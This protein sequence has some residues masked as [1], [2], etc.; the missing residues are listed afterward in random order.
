MSR[1][2]KELGGCWLEA[3]PFDMPPLCGDS[4]S[5]VTCNGRRRDQ[6]GQ[7]AVGSPHGKEGGVLRGPM[8]YPDSIV[9]ST[10]PVGAGQLKKEGLPVRRTRAGGGDETGPTFVAREEK[11]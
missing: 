10:G 6:Q 4:Q 9:P 5:R 1:V 11:G 2:S 7:S 3:S 8:Q